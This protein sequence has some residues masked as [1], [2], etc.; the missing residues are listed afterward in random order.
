MPLRT[1]KNIHIFVLVKQKNRPFTIFHWKYGMVVSLIIIPVSFH[2]D[3]V[4][5]F[6]K[7]P[8]F[9]K[10]CLQFP[11]NAFFDIQQQLKETRKVCASSTD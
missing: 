10:L 5:Y 9:H 7:K 8:N 1:G 4:Y 6:G 3:L 11:P 2:L